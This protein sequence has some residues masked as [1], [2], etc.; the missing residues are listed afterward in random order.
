MGQYQALQRAFVDRGKETP[1]WGRD[2]TRERTCHWIAVFAW[3]EGPWLLAAQ[4]FVYHRHAGFVS[5][6]I[7]ISYSCHHVCFD[8]IAGFVASSTCSLSDACSD[9]LCRLQPSSPSIGAVSTFIVFCR[10]SGKL[11]QGRGTLCRLSQAP[12]RE[13]AFS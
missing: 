9:C 4:R 1:C 5:S 11:A 8:S 10:F 2:V 7:E 12:E 3:P 6:A 13:A